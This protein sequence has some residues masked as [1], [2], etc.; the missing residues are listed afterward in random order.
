MIDQG[1]GSQTRWLAPARAGCPEALGRLL[2]CYRPY[3]LHLARRQLGQG[4]RAKGDPGDLVQETFLEAYRE[5]DRFQ[6][7]SEAEWRAWLRRMLRNNALNF[8][9]RYRGTAKRAAA[10]ECPVA[11]TESTPGPDADHGSPLE[12]LIAAEEA[13]RL[14]TILARLPADYR[15]VL[16][17]WARE[18]LSFP[19][20]GGRLGRTANAARLLWL[21]ALECVKQRLE[22][23]QAVAG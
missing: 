1:E 7:H 15:E 17:L 5:I 12:H 10:R 19:E 6:G 16:L 22:R 8:V 2:E 3:L 20:I 13:S 14:R 21:R 23:R 9:R 18:Q 4:L 11:A